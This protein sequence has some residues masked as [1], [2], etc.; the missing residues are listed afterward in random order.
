MQE[1]HTGIINLPEDQ[2]LV[3]KMIQ[4]LYTC[5]YDNP[6]VSEQLYSRFHIDMFVLGDKYAILRLRDLAE[7]NF[8][9][10][11]SKY[12]GTYPRG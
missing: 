11:L 2:S 5:K 10:A 3:E 6:S 4:F 12:E 7:T 9:I 8:G 1:G